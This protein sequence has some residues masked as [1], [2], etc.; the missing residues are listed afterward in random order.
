[1][2]VEAPSITVGTQN[3]LR[4]VVAIVS[5]SPLPSASVSPCTTV[6]TSPSLPLCAALVI[7]ASS[8]VS[9]SIILRTP[10]APSFM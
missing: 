2:P 9:E 10:F 5:A 7:G 3:T 1:M 6:R 8:Y 4:P